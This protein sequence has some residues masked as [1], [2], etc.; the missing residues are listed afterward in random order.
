MQT[1]TEF[2]K[3]FDEYWCKLEKYFP[4]QTKCSIGWDPKT[5]NLVYYAA[6]KNNFRTLF[7][8]FILIIFVELITLPSCV[9]LLILVC[10]GI[11]TSTSFLT[12]IVTLGF[13]M[14]VSIATVFHLIV[15][16]YGKDFVNGWNQLRKLEESLDLDNSK[17]KGW[18]VI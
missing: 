13:A 10:N 3:A 5:R 7:W 8:H 16:S 12:D 18:P 15:V 2:F 11:A 17:F 6:S 14:C 4:I 1:K 9:F